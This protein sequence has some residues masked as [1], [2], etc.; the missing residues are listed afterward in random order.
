M[1]ALWTLIA[2]LRA[3]RQRWGVI[4][5]YRADA[6]ILAGRVAAVS[7]SVRDLLP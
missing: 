3:Q 4:R 5:E 7:P 2:P 6:M 1:I